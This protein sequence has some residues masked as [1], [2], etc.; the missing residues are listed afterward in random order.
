VF[1]KRGGLDDFVYI[2]LLRHGKHAEARACR[3]QLLHMADSLIRLARNVNTRTEYP[4][5]E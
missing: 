5:E 3:L 4:Q 2:R 1:G